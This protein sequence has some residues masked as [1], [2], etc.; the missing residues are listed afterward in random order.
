[1]KTS[2][3]WLSTTRVVVLA[4]LF[5]FCCSDPA[6]DEVTPPKNEQEKEKEEEMS[7]V[8]ADVALK[9]FSFTSARQITG[10]VPTVV[11]S[12]LLKTN[13][14]DTVYV[15][16]E[17]K[18]LIRISH[19]ESR[20]VKGIY[21]AVQGSTFY[22]DV[23]IDEEEESDTV[24]VILFEIEPENIEIPY[25]IPVDITAYDDSGQPIDILERIITV[26]KPN[27]NMCDILDDGDTATNDWARTWQ[28]RWTT[29]LD[30]NDQPVRIH[31]PGRMYYS[32]QTHSGCCDNSACPA[33]VV[34]P[35]T[36]IG[37]W[38]YDSEFTVDTHYAI[39]YEGFKF[40]KNGTFTRVTIERQSAV[41]AD[42]TDWC[43]GVPQLTDYL[44]DVTYFGGHDYSPGDT[45]I[46]YGTTRSVCA[47]PLGLCGYG[48]RGGQLT[49]SCH[50]MIITAGVEGQKEMRMYTRTYG[51]PVLV[52]EE[53]ITRTIWKD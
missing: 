20:P 30:Q 16:P 44:D 47:D 17:I 27:N 10:A 2:M 5:L 36:K 22:Y 9:A 51:N 42:G 50:A 3:R 29:L 18:N 26:E 33:Y 46:S 49:Y 32:S 7:Q 41:D 13:S 15:L 23:P 37:K 24:S 45:K 31:A 6:E 53:G 35:N 48:S 52:E 11:N 14:R 40:Y 38:V 8:D 1:M 34:D 21:L 28:W 19:P 25:D 43:N 39:L 12:S 4:V